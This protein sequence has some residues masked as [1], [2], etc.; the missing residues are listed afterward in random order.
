MPLPCMGGIGAGLR[1]DHRVNKA[2]TGIRDLLR[3]LYRM[4]VTNLLPNCKA[5]VHA[6]RSAICPNSQSSF[7]LFLEGDADW[8]SE[9]VASHG[10]GT[11]L[12]S[13]HVVETFNHLTKIPFNDHAN[14]GAQ[15]SEGP[16]GARDAKEDVLRQV[17]DWGFSYLH[18]PLAI[19]SGLRTQPCDSLR[20]CPE[21]LSPLACPK[22]VP[23]QGSR[24]PPTRSH[25]T[26]GT[27][28]HRQKTR[29]ALQG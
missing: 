13:G 8:M 9:Q 7:L 11:A 26:P 21:W 18:V 14:R 23:T 22:A 12:F 15:W 4:Y 27:C 5:V 28:K 2:I 1:T 20:P 19:G 24:H 6:F 10:H 17:L 25:S 29:H 3:D 16:Q